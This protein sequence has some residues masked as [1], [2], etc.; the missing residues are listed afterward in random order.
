MQLRFRRFDLAL[1]HHWAIATDL[2][3]GGGKSVYPVVFVELKDS[4]GRTGL[5]EASPSSQ[6]RETHETVSEFLGRVESARLSFDDVEGGMAYIEALAPGAYP[7]KCALNIALLDGASKAAGKPLCEHLGLGPFREG[8]HL[9]S[10]TIG[11]DTPDAMA[12]KT[13][14]AAD[15]PILKM[16]LGSPGDRANFAAVRGAA[17]DRWI[18]VDANAGWKSREEALRNIEWLAADGRVEFV[19]QPMPPELPDEDWAW[20]KERSPLPL[21][22]DELFQSAADADRCAVC[23][24][25]VNVKLVKTGGVSRG[26]EALEAARARGLKTMLGCMIESSI[27]ISA[28][29]HLAALTDYLD[30]DGNVLITNDPYRG[31]INRGGRISFEG[32]EPMAGLRVAAR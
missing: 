29:S 26:K 32:V 28:A 8:A 15:Y 10:F 12:R 20:L 13:L 17:P 19:E 2:G 25:G 5:G 14:E 1:R 3:R 6:Y 11:I 31:V 16:K 27:L 4:Q 9:S 7:A 23:V 22:G 18:R 30:L 21:I 24:H